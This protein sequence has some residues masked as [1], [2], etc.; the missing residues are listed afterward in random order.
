MKAFLDKNL[1]SS[2][3]C[4][5]YDYWQIPRSAVYVV[6][7]GAMEH[8]AFRQS[9]C[10]FKFSSVLSSPLSTLPPVPAASASSEVLF[11]FNWLFNRHFDL[12]QLQILPYDKARPSRG[13]LVSPSA[14]FEGQM[15]QRWY[16]GAVAVHVCLCSVTPNL[17]ATLTISL[18]T[19]LFIWLQ[20]KYR[21]CFFTISP[22]RPS[23]LTQE[24]EFTF[25]AL[26]AR[27]STFITAESFAMMILQC[28]A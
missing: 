4:V 17:L 10:A 8:A 2:F 9:I 11:I 3:R 23:F 1:I 20:A 7:M 22:S 19:L 26:Y 25:C 6:L 24:I 18:S 21:E 16:P 12:D 27:I 28:L 15:L 5:K 14:Y 13:S